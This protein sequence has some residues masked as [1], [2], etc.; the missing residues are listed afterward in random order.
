MEKITNTQELYEWIISHN[1]FNG[2]ISE[3]EVFIQ[4]PYDSSSSINIEEID[5]I[6][7]IILKVA[8]ELEDFSA[9][10]EFDELWSREFGK[11]NNFTPSEFMRAL[12]SDEQA[13]LELAKE[14]RE[15]LQS[16]DRMLNN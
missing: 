5:D 13:L 1:N 14:L 7:T 15:I 8:E 6:N 10:N 12:M 9:D 2:Y 4:A 11:E 16:S 3:N